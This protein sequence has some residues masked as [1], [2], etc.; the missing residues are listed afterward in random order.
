[1]T[2]PHTYGSSCAASYLLTDFPPAPEKPT[3]PKRQ[4]KKT[5]ANGAPPQAAPLAGSGAAAG[6]AACAAGGE[7]TQSW[8]RATH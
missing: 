3:K 2:Q 8:W 6:V 7:V 4:A 5:R 1:M